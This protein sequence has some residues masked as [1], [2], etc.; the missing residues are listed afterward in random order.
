MWSSVYGELR[1][2]SVPVKGGEEQVE[3]EEERKKKK[4]KKRDHDSVH[5]V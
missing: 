1:G 4:K 5:L 3:G 2:I